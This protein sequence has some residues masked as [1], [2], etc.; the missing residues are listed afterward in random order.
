MSNEIKIAKAQWWQSLGLAIFATGFVLIA[1]ASSFLG[2]AVTT[3][4]TN[5]QIA[6]LN[7]IPII[8]IVG[9]F[10][11]ILGIIIIAYSKCVLD[12]I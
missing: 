6:F 1:L 2:V 9:L 8:L 3:T 12:K 4:N 5:L 7:N 11:L 10:V